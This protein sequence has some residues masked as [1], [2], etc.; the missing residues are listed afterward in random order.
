M[1]SFFYN[2]LRILSLSL[3]IFVSFL[4]VWSKEREAAMCDGEDGFTLGLDVSTARFARL[5]GG[6]LE[7]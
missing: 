7:R 5:H 3:F 2:I 6:A 1:L 4:R